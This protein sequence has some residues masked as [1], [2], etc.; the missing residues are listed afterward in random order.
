MRSA[1]QV[2]IALNAIRGDRSIKEVVRAFGTAR[3]TL[4]D[5][6]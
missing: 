6:P 1:E 4:P 3:S 5:R 2:E